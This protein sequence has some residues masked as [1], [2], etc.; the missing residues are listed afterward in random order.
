MSIETSPV[1]TAAKP[2]TAKAAGSAKSQGAAKGAT[3]GALGFGAILAAEDATSASATDPQSSSSSNSLESKDP[4]AP[5]GSAQP[6]I[7]LIATSDAALILPSSLSV[8]ASDAIATTVAEGGAG[9]SADATSVPGAFSPAKGPSG[10]AANAALLSG[11]GQDAAT[12]VPA[13]G[14]AGTASAAPDT[15]TSKTAKPGLPT[16][17]NKSTAGVADSAKQ[18]DTQFFAALEAMKSM[19]SAKEPV[20]AVV[21]VALAATGLS[22]SNKTEKAASAADTA[23]L[24]YTG[25]APTLGTTS[26]A[27]TAVGDTANVSPDMQVAEQVTYWISQDVQN[28]ELTL[29][30]LGKDPVEVSIRMSGNEAQVSFRT[31]ELQTRDLLE[32]AA[33]HLKE[34]LQREGLV[35]SGVSVGSSGSGDAG[36]GQPRQ[37]QGARQT[38]SVLAAPQATVAN[39]VPMGAQGRSLD[40]FV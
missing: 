40:L 5:V 27:S 11:A 13:T 14:A 26:Y 19:Q 34:L 20:S 28:A 4:L 2:A 16:L 17:D 1:T 29:D 32:N 37:H 24:T 21:G 33:V 38:A 31:D 39:R 15:K 18:H 23:P 8:P 30:G 3:D 10:P 12:P 36:S 22:E 35:L 25:S 6:A 7:N 9:A